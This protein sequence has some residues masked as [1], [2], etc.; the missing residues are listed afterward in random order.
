MN[1]FDKNVSCD[2]AT[3]AWPHF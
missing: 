1:S 3:S 2:S